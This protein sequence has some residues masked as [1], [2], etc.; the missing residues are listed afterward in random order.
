MASNVC[1]SKE[2]D[3]VHDSSKLLV[4]ILAFEWRSSKGEVSTI[5][6]EL[7]V[8]LAK[9]SCV[10]VTLLL[11]KCSDEDT[12]AAASHSVSILRAVER[13]GYK[14]EL[15]WLRFPPED[16]KIDVVVGHG[17]KLGFLAQFIRHS[18]NCKWVQIV[19]TDPEELGMFKCYENPTSTGE[20]KHHI[21][22]KLCQMADF[23][24]G[25]GPKLT[26]AFCRYLSWCKRDVDVFS[27]TPGILNDLP[28]VQQVPVKQEQCI[29]LVCGGGVA[30]DIELKGFDI[31]ARSVAALSDTCLYFVGALDG[32]HEKIAKRFVDLGIPA[33][34]LKVR[35]HV[36][37]REDLKRL[38]REIDLVLMIS[39]TEGFGL[40]GLEALSAGLPV[41]VSKNSGFGEALGSVPCG[42]LFVIDSED[43]SQ[44][45]AGIK[46]IWNRDRKSQLDEVDAVRCLYG[47]RY[48][49]SAQCQHL[50][51][52]MFKLF[53]G[54]NYILILMTC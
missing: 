46:G 45:T 9:F 47:E 27:F 44:W 35:G 23:V 22:V 20:Q 42:S 12:T 38:F 6:R 14:S 36:E 52:K 2:D 3:P 25:I 50:I 34:R 30:E 1:L 39:R 17:V 43:P 53:D 4:T 21:E 5:N 8:Q 29:V 26:E 33:N 24:V 32:K 13:P 16:F 19:N 15:H 40:I 37:S 28:I 18:H 54:M 11:P 31:A 41:L 10:E 51:E 48:S 7:A 49:W